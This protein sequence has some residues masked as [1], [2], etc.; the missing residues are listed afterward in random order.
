MLRFF[1]LGGTRVPRTGKIRRQAVP[2]PLW[3]ILLFVI[4]EVVVIGWVIL[5]VLRRQP[6]QVAVV[7]E[8]LVRPPPTLVR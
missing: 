7:G 3:G 4:G 5:F 8:R 2:V 6:R 1:P